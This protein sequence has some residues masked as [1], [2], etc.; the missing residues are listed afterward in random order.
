MSM[1]TPR[2]TRTRCTA[3]SDAVPVRVLVQVDCLAQDRIALQA[4][5]DTL[6]LG[7]N[8]EC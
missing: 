6:E 5:H 3:M 4:V 7:I 1:L 2:R 8:G